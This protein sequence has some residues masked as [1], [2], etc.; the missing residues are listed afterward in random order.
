MDF[1]CSLTGKSP[2][3]T[4][5][6]SE[7]ALTKGPFN[8]LVP[9]TDLN[10]ALL[11]YI[12]S[13]YQGFSSA[14]G[15]VG[16]EKRF[17]HDISILI[18][19][20]WARLEPNDRDAKLL[21][22]NN[23]LE[24][25]E[26]FEY[27][28][29]KIMASRLGYRITKNFAFRCMNRLFDEP[30]AVF[31]ERMLKPELHGMEEFVDGINNIVEA[32]QKVALRYFEE[33]SVG[34]A[35]PPLQILLHI[36]AYGNYEGKDMSHPELRKQFDRDYVIQT[37]WYKNRL[38]LKQQK[39]SGFLKKQIE[40]LNE[41]LAQPNNASLVKEMQ[42]N[43]LIEKAQIQLEYIESE[44]YLSDLMGTIGADPLFKN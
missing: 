30:L 43:N 9:T 38:K 26:D 31:N 27:N 25:L 40:Y 7:G 4:G 17:D 24:K 33:G 6:G 20:I 13:E 11:S 23:C 19:E 16:Q 12:L 10:N 21:I 41:F 8:M 22:Q 18:P 14:A 34:S 1:I 5:A 2:S 42:L 29:K 44:K 36:M 3:T 39:D 15:Y 35:I 37:D 28:G 32:Q